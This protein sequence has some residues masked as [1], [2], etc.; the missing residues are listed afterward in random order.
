MLQRRVWILPEAAGEAMFHLLQS[1]FSKLSWTAEWMVSWNR[2]SRAL[3]GDTQQL[4]R[5]R[6]VTRVT[7][8]ET[9]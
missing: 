1:T 4:R 2:Q 9:G 5:Q 8:G 6:T 3:E 7:A